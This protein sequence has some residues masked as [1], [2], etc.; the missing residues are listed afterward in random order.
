MIRFAPI[1]HRIAFRS[2]RI[3]PTWRHTV[4]SAQ[5]MNLSVT[6]LENNVIPDGVSASDKYAKE[7][8]DANRKE[9]QT[10]TGTDKTAFHFK[11]ISQKEMIDIVEKGRQELKNEDISSEEFVERNDIMR[12][13]RRGEI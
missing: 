8:E 3:T 7:E 13:S 4:P 5:N 12:K 11:S 10:S 9:N 2:G 6:A 1:P